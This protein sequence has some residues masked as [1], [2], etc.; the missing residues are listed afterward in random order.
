MPPL[1]PSAPPAPPAP[2]VVPIPLPPMP[3]PSP[4]CCQTSQ[5][6]CCPQ[7]TVNNQQP[8]PCCQQQQQ[9][10]SSSCCQQQQQQPQWIPGIPWIIQSPV[11]VVQE[12]YPF[13]PQ[14]HPIPGPGPVIPGSPSQNP[15]TSC[16]QACAAALS[17]ITS[18]PYNGYGRKRR[19]LAQMQ[20]K[21]EEVRSVN[22]IFSITNLH[23]WKVAVLLRS[24]VIWVIQKQACIY[25]SWQ[26]YYSAQ[27]AIAL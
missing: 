9:Q 22:H 19:S 5:P 3:P 14:P 6:I 10:Q 13:I 27:K 11:P 7:P 16:C 8:S 21:L 23:L 20:H 2:P 12:P 18:W 17:A 24:G 1:P 4:S 15:N 25:F 26:F